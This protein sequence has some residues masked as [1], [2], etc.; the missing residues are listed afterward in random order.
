[1]FT[2]GS[3]SSSSGRID[4][5]YSN[6]NDV[7]HLPYAISVFL[8]RIDAYHLDFDFWNPILRTLY[9]LTSR[10]HTVRVC[11]NLDFFVRNHD[12]ANAKN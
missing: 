2:L 6:V 7:D 10:S 12:C 5:A 3:L 11:L 9:F 4:D 8:P 1:M